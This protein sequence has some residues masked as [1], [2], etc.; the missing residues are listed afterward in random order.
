MES[1]FEESPEYRAARSQVRRLRGF[2]PILRSIS[3]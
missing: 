2:M 3:P 1:T